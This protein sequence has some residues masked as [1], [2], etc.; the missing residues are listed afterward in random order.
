MK[1]IATALFLLSPFAIHANSE[2]SHKC[3]NLYSS[4][5]TEAMSVE[6]LQKIDQISLKLTY[7][8]E[9]TDEGCSEET[10][11]Q[12]AELLASL[13]NGRQIIEVP[14]SLSW[15][16]GIAGLIV[17]TNVW[18]LL[19]YGGNM[20][21]SGMKLILN[22]GVYRWYGPGLKGVGFSRVGLQTKF[23]YFVANL[24]MLPVL[25][26]NLGIARPRRQMG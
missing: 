9:D 25:L 13:L 17:G 5:K 1:H 16:C 24:T 18:S 6:T 3:A 14:V 12:A 4:L 21:I 26:K 22:Q 7:I 11:Q 2:E 8:T 20:P 19:S 23:L 10:K 15:H